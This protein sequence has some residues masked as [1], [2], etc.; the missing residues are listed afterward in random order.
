MDPT[1]SALGSLAAKLL[2]D[3]FIS[4]RKR[5]ISVE[6]LRSRMQEVAISNEDLRIT[7]EVNERRVEFLETLIATLIASGAFYRQADAIRV[8]P[9]TSSQE[10]GQI[11]QG[12]VEA[13]DSLSAP[14]ATVSP[15][16]D[17]AGTSDR[18]SKDVDAVALYLGGFV[19]E[20]AERRRAA[21]A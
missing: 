15:G 17:P 4:G 9:D 19:E 7:A 5:R 12:A 2:G 3:V 14:V 1:L 18:K 13:A 10:I 8:T 21:G 20:L 6:E 11:I 16:R